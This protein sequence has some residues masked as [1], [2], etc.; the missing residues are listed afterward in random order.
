MLWGV[1]SRGV[2][3]CQWLR[4]GFKKS[5]PKPNCLGDDL[6]LR[7][8]ALFLNCFFS[9]VAGGFSIQLSN[10]YISRGQENSHSVCLR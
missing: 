5:S 6:M 4:I 7:Q 1:N 8:F 2:F 9:F 3:C 10:L